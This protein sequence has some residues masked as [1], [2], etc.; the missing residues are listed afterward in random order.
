MHAK[1]KTLMPKDVHLVRTIIGIW[2]PS[3]WLAKQKEMVDLT[4]V[5]TVTIPKSVMP[6]G[7]ISRSKK[8]VSRK[9]KGNSA[10]TGKR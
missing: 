3:S 2:D 7:A 6:S 9:G 8:V 1:R 4:Q 5:K 10:N